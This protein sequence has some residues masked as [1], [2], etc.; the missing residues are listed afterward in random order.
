MAGGKIR[1]K[2]VAERAGVAVNTAS[3]ILNR[4][5]NSWASKETEERVFAAAKELGYRPNRAAVALRSGKFKTIGLLVADFENPYYTHF[6]Q[7]FGN[8]AA[9]QGYDLVIESWQT[10][11]EREKKSLEE[12]VHRNVDGVL[13]FVSDLE[14]HREFLE[15]QSQMG[16][17]VVVFAMPGE[18][19]APVDMVV[20]DFSTGLAEAAEFLH[21]L[22]HRK[23]G[24]LAAHA[25]GQQVGGRPETFT[26]LVKGFGDSEVEVIAC[27]PSVAEARDVGRQ[28]LEREDRPTAIVALNDYTAI[29]VIRAAIQ[30]GLKV[31]EDVSVVGIDGIPLGEHLMISLST[32]VQDY[33]GM[34]A[35]AVE[36]LVGR[37]D[38]KEDEKP[39]GVFFPTAYVQR[40]SVGPAN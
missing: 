24:F 27:G 25:R 37:I 23:F 12:M 21:E 7:V 1:L 40:D 15:Q 26:K 34:A 13:A 5:P 14:A 18:G 36:F 28:I 11:V 39:R 19:K 17:P 3:T 6:C 20:P 4:R 16:F 9:V 22:G 38:G 29:G 8:L 31:P 2:D 33:K 35:Q 10:D 32:I 30:M